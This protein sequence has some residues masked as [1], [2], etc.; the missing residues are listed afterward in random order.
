MYIFRELL[1]SSKSGDTPPKRTLIHLQ[2]YNTSVLQLVTLPNILLTWCTSLRKSFNLSFFLTP[3]DLDTSTHADTYRTSMNDDDMAPTIHNVA[4]G[5]L[6]I[7]PEFKAAF[8]ETLQSLN[9]SLR[10]F[11]GSWDTFNPVS[12]SADPAESAKYDILLTSETIYRNESL[13]P[14]IDLM[15]RACPA[16]S[17]DANYLCLVAA[18][19]LYFGVGGGV[20]DFLEAVEKEKATVETVL[21]RT[22][23]VGRKIMRVRW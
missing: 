19:V 14:L 23:G 13:R 11:S 12:T 20:S 3:F 16:E 9:I 4:S 18:K 17:A 1:S 8:L 21:E 7:T 6:P 5:E 10:F 15:R 22:A 2:D